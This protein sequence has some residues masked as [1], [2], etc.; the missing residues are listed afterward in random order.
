MKRCQELEQKMA[1]GGEFK[2]ATNPANLSSRGKRRSGKIFGR[3]LGG[4]IQVEK[5]STGVYAR[6]WERKHLKTSHKRK[7]I[8]LRKLKVY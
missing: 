7:N 5:T 3:G 8:D 2:S 4:R 6:P 1:E